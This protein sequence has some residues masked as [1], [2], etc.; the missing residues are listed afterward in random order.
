VAQALEEGVLVEVGLMMSGTEQRD[1]PVEARARLRHQIEH[2]AVEL[3]HLAIALAQHEPRA[4]RRAPPALPLE[5]RAPRARHPQ[6]RVDGQ[7]AL[8]AQEQVLAV[9]VDRADGPALQAFGPAVH[10]KARV[11]G[12]QLVRHAALEDRPDAVGRVVDRVALG[13]VRLG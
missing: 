8:E 3:H 5:V 10:A 7:P 6:V 4:A 9:G 11:R 2:R 13:H 12:G 1:P